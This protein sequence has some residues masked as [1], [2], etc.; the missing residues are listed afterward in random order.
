[1]L[2]FDTQFFDDALKICVFHKNSTAKA[3]LVAK[4]VLPIREIVFDRPDFE[5][6][7]FYPISMKQKR[8]NFVAGTLFCECE[9][10][11]MD[12]NL[13]AP[14]WITSLKLSKDL[15]NKYEYFNDHLANEFKD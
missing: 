15:D 9:Y 7:N 2:E 12:R 13:L 8:T 6:D 11:A 10:K 3:H 1:V 5:A 4:R 14:E